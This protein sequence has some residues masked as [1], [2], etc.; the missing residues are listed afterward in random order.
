MTDDYYSPCVSSSQSDVPQE[1]KI[2]LPF[3]ATGMFTFGCAGATAGAAT[4]LTGA[5]VAVAVGRAG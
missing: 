1:N 2:H 5:A 3:S 4:F